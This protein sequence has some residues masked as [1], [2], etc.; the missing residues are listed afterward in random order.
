MAGTSGKAKRLEGIKI[1]VYGNDN[2]GIQ[3]TT[4]CQSYGWLP[5]SANGEMNGTEGEAKRLEAIKIQLT[6][7]DKDKY[8]VFITECMHSLMAGL[9][10]RRTVHHLEL[11]AMQRDSK[12]SRSW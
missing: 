6:G 8:D 10:G 4:H 7:A 3:Y 11:Q 5:W 12:E 1:R 2:L 9:A